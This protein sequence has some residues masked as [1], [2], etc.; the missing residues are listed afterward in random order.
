MLLL[1]AGQRRQH[2]PEAALTTRLK[3]LVPSAGGGPW[4][5]AVHVLEKGRKDGIK[6][7]KAYNVVLKVK[8]GSSLAH[9]PRWIFGKVHR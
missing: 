1:A 6:D 9:A 7:V 2:S 4:R 5:L 3:G 8:A